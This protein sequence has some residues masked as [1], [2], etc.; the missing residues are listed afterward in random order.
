LRNCERKEG[1]ME[2]KDYY[3]TLGVSKSATQEEMKKAYRKLAVKYHPDKNKN[4]K[5]AEEK[6]KE[7]TEAYEVLGDV[8]KR[9][10]YD[11]VGANWKQYEYANQGPFNGGYGRQTYTTDDAEDMFGGSHFSDFFESLFGRSSG[12]RTSG[13]DFDFRGTQTRDMTGDVVITL[14]E[15]YHGTQRIVD[16]GG[17]KIRVSVKPGAYDGLKLRVKGKGEGTADRRGNLI[18]NIKV[19]PENHAQRRGDDLYI[20]VNIDLYTAL[21]GGKQEIDTFS[22]KVQIQI[23]E[24]SQND[25]L[26]RLAGKGMPVYGKEGAFGDLYIRLKVVLPTKLTPQQKELVKKV[27]D[28]SSH[29][30]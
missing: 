16:L 21:L 14:Q 4:D 30:S 24:G 25:K 6:F 3:K 11:S 17:E 29:Q 19:Q 1:F 28:L 22:G 13:F 9:K 5:A 20:D 27:K 10:K 8:E 12:R 26:L 7:I 2:Y 15:A 23:P 18:L